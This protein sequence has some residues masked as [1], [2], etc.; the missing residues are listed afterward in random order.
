MAS[1]RETDLVTY[2][3]TKIDRFS[4]RKCQVQ[5]PLLSSKRVCLLDGK[6]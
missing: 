3:V 2:S 1:W 4:K 6:R 5:I